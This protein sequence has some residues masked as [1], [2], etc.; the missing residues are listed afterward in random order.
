MLETL[1]LSLGLID[2]FFV[3]REDLRDRFLAVLENLNEQQVVVLLGVP[4]S[5]DVEKYPQFP[6]YGAYKWTDGTGAKSFP[7]A[8][9]GF[10][11]LS[12]IDNGNVRIIPL[13]DNSR[14]MPLS[15]IP[16][17][18]PPPPGTDMDKTT[19]SYDAGWLQVAADRISWAGG[20]IAVV[21]LCGPTMSNVGIATLRNNT[22]PGRPFPA[23]SQQKAPDYY[24]VKTPQS[25]PIPESIGINVAVPQ[26]KKV[27]TGEPCALFGSFALPSVP[28]TAVVIHLLFSSA[29]KPGIHEYSVTIPP[30]ATSMKDSIARGYFLFDMMKTMYWKPGQRFDVPEKLFISAVSRQVFCAPMACSFVSE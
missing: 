26:K 24:F 8:D 14:K 17:K 6:L 19:V 20:K 5:W 2:Q 27:I 23:V 7:P 3:Q 11:V 16:E 21:V 29:D 12:S 28:H 18:S 10:I 13:V 9:F 25:P 1:V 22:N 15:N 4:K 30:E